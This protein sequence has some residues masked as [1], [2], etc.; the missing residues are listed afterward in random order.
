M[1]IKSMW[2]YGAHAASLAC[3]V[4]CQL[5]ELA[6]SA[7]DRMSDVRRLYEQLSPEVVANYDRAL[8][9]VVAD[10]LS[11]TPA[12]RPAALRRLMRGRE[13]RE[14][15]VFLVVCMIAAERISALLEIRDTWRDALQPGCGFRG[16]LSTSLLLPDRCAGVDHCAGCQQG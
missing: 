4:A 16:A 12:Q 14:Q 13:R 3:E 15:Y 8:T 7:G 1:A 9:S 11:K 6:E 5:C 10:F 2:R